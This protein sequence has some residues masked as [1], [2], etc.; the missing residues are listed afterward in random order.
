MASRRLGQQLLDDSPIPSRFNDAR[1]GSTGNDDITARVLELL[2]S[3]NMELK[4][5]TEVRLRHMIS[6][7]VGAYEIKLRK[8]REAI[9]ERRLNE[10]E[11][12]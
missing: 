6:S 5:S 9:F 1:L 4:G 11:S 7:E 2:R 8:S 3:N 10:L 12:A